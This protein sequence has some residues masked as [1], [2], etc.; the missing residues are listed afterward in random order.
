MVPMSLTVGGFA[1]TVRSRKLIARED[2]MLKL[3]SRLMMFELASQQSGR[4]IGGT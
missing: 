1:V 4:D 3:R 2:R